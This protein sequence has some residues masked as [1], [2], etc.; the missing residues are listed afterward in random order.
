MELINSVAHFN[1]AYVQCFND[2]Y[3]SKESNPRKPSLNMMDFK[4]FRLFHDWDVWGDSTCFPELQ[5]TSVSD[6]KNKTF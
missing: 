3:A 5:A 1:R 4:A 6:Y 2:I